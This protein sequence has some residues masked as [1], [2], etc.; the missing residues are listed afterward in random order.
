MFFCFSFLLFLF[1][2][3]CF[4]YVYIVGGIWLEAFL[5]GDIYFLKIIFGVFYVFSKV[6]VFVNALYVLFR[7]LFDF[8]LFFFSAYFFE[9]DFYSNENQDK[10]NWSIFR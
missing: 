3:K 4:R 1:G 7:C 6:V 10:S 9:T 2:L 5:K 8:Q